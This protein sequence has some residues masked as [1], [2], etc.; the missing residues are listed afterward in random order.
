MRMPAPRIFC[1]FLTACALL[2]PAHAWGQAYPSR[3]VRLIV[4]FPAG[5]PADIF[6]R[7]LGQGMSIQLG[8]PVLIENVSGVGGVLGVECAAKST[9]DGY[10][11]VL[12]SSSAVAISPF[13]MAS[14][15]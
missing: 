8:Q 2:L 12:N 5:G 10:T 7:F 15:P 6:G 11:L 3:P 4:P 1:T 13:S 9:P 14:R